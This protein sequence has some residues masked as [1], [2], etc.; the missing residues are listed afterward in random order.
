MSGRGSV[1]K[2]KTSFKK[3]ARD[4]GHNV[5]KERIGAKEAKLALKRGKRQRS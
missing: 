3:G 4:N 5:A 2:G 1:Q